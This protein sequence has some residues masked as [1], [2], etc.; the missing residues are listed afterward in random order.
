[1][2]VS[3]YSLGRV[4]DYVKRVRDRGGP[5][6]DPLIRRLWIPVEIKIEFMQYLSYADL[7]NI[8][9]VCK[10]WLVLVNKTYEAEFHAKTG[11]VAPKLL[12][13]IDKLRLLARIRKPLARDNYLW[14]LNF[15]AGKQGM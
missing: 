5:V 4:P 9:A 8:S 11:A 6:T 15:A 3:G 12:P 14:L 7:A 10:A 1:M 2:A 13:R